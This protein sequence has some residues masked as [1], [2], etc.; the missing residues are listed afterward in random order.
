MIERTLNYQDVALDVTEVYAALGYQDGAI[1]DAPTLREVTSILSEVAEHLEAR[2]ALVTASA[3]TLQGFSTGRI[4]Q[5]QLRGVQAVC[6]FVATAGAWFEAFQQRL[7]QEGDMVR[8][9]I[10]NEIGS[11]LAEKTAD[12]ME[13]VLEEQLT[14][15]GLG[16]TNRFS[17]GYC[18]WPV[19]EQRLLFSKFADNATA[20]QPTAQGCGELPQPCGI[21]LTDSCLM[22]P[23]KSVSGVIGIG[24]DI[25]KHDYRCSICDLKSC[26]KRRINGQKAQAHRP[27]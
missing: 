6:Y 26:Y 14:P 20:T 8:V 5:A 16:H 17:P 10:A 7:M 12:R 3:D 4:I 9:Y 13:L 22:V 19:S 18:G 15:K 27:D 2:L 25:K 21:R 23:I 11:L 24:R 1:P